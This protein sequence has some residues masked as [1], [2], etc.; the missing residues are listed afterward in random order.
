VNKA[1]R[2]GDGTAADDVT[3]PR[4]AA[5]ASQE[6]AEAQRPVDVVVGAKHAGTAMRHLLA[7]EVVAELTG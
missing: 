6:G 2:F 7:P 5:K 1:I 4:S 3:E